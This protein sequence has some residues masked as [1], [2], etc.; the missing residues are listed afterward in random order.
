M[1][2]KGISAKDEPI[3]N[4]KESAHSVKITVS[5]DTKNL[6]LNGCKEEFLTHHPELKGM[7]LTENF[8]VRQIF[9]HYLRS[10]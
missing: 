7:K 1:S 5:E 10:P 3:N 8:L 4:H 2:K 6:L 9:E